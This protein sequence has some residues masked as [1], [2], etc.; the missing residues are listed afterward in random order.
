MDALLSSIGFA[1]RRKTGEEFFLVLERVGEDH[2]ESSDHTEV[3]E[4]ER[5]VE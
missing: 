5:E 3:S 1:E 2:Q 4:E